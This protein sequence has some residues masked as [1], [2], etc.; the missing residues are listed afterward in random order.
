MGKAFSRLDE[1]CLE[2]DL[3]RACRALKLP[4]FSGDGKYLVKYT[5]AELKDAIGQPE[6]DAQNTFTARLLLLLERSVGLVRA[7]SAVAS[8]VRRVSQKN[9]LTKQL[10]R[11]VAETPH[12]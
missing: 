7:L 4:E 2:A 9:S 5:I 11:R 3:I 10:A 1:I 6:D 12:T 8:R